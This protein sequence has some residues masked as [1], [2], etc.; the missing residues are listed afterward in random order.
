MI[1]RRCFDAYHEPWSALQALFRTCQKHPCIGC[2][3]AERPNRNR[4]SLMNQQKA[5]GMGKRS[6]CLHL[7][8]DKSIPAQCAFEYDLP[9]QSA[10]FDQHARSKRSRPL[11][12]ECVSHYPFEL[13]TRSGRR[14]DGR[15]LRKRES[16]S[17]KS[18]RLRSAARI[19]VIVVRLGAPPARRQKAMAPQVP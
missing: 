9:V 14:Q 1:V 11:Y 12:S 15:P 5:L 4:R 18:D 6:L 13:A 17:K 8:L 2:L 3:F 10:Q 16:R 7:V 19:D